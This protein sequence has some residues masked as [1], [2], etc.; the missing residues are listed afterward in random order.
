MSVTGITCSSCA[1]TAEDHLKK[2]Y[3]VLSV[4]V[5][6][7]TAKVEVIYHNKSLTEQTILDHINTISFKA[8]I[9]ADALVT[10]LEVILENKE[11]QGEIE[12]YL[13]DLTGVKGV[14]TDQLT[15]RKSQSEQKKKE[16]VTSFIIEYDPD[17]NG[18]RTIMEALKNSFESVI[19]IQRETGNNSKKGLKTEVTDWFN[20]LMACLALAIPVIILAFVLPSIESSKQAIDTIVYNG[21]FQTLVLV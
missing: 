13:T 17:K 6:V 5:S 11:Q 16:L 20:R 18:S 15:K 9:V 10:N 21:W 4:N 7:T 2:L 19:V 14:K 12:R 8:E 1:K 3:G